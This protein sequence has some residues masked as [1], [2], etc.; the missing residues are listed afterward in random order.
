[1][2]KLPTIKVNNKDVNIYCALGDKKALDM[3]Y[4]LAS[5]IPDLPQSK[6]DEEFINSFKTNLK[7]ENLSKNGKEI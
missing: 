7:K 2:I 4:K 3:W 1:M 6:E 5:M